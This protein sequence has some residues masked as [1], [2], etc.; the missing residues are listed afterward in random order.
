MLKLSWCYYLWDIPVRC[1]LASWRSWNAFWQETSAASWTCFHDKKANVS[2]K[3]K[4]PQQVK[5][6]PPHS[7]PRHTDILHRGGKT[8]PAPQQRHQIL[9]NQVQEAGLQLIYITRGPAVSN[10]MP[11]AVFNFGIYL[12]N[13]VV[14]LLTSVRV[15]LGGRSLRTWWR[16]RQVLFFF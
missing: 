9:P 16:R 14:G 7:D 10:Q 4:S 8:S 12:H 1:N 6:F 5:S 13:S 2:E 11:K 15:I 3:P